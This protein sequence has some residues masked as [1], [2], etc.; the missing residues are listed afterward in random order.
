MANHILHPRAFTRAA[1]TLVELLV[2]LAIIAILVTI[3]IGVAAAVAEGG[4]QRAT[5][6]VL[7]ALDQ[8]LDIYIDTTGANPPAVVTAPPNRIVGVL[9][10]DTPVVLPMVDG[11]VLPNANSALAPYDSVG[12]YLLAAEQL[13]EVQSIIAGLDQRL[14]RRVRTGTATNPEGGGGG[15]QS[16]QFAQIEL[17]LTSIVDA[18]GNPIRI[19]HPRFDGVIRGAGDFG[20]VNLL[21]LGDNPFIVVGEVPGNPTYS[22]PYRH[23]RRLAPSRKEWRGYTQ[24]EIDE[25]YLNR[26]GDSDGGI[27]PTPRPYFYSAGP[28]GD[29]ST[30]EDNVYT[31]RPR[32]QDQ[33]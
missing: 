25:N 28:D 2:V 1:F 29:P 15:A 32:F 6:G 26:A 3:T 30:I 13:P 7:R 10:R 11:I 12:V 5:E 33:N 9:A 16:G 23:I 24:A 8:T 22:L 19:V 18:W 4:R 21:P 14:V 20:L 17:E 27:C 31:T